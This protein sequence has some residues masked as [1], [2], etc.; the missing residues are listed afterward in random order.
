MLLDTNVLFSATLTDTLLRLAEE[1]AFI[2]LW[3]QGILLELREVL[4]REAGLEPGAADR[5]ISHM[6]RAFPEAEVFAYETIIESMTCEPKDRHVLAAAVRGRAQV[7]VTFNVRDFPETSTAAHDISVVHPDSFLL[8]QLDLHPVKVGRALMAQ[9][10]EATRPRL[11]FGELFGRL[12]RAG[13]P[14]FAEE[15]RRHEFS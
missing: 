9:I 14:T 12:D 10:S 8:D 11:S 6:A 4:V 13:V 7:L 5:R 3:S 2:P 15:A 1:E